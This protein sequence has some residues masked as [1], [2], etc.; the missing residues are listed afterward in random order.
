MELILL[1]VLMSLSAALGAIVQRARMIRLLERAAQ[2][3]RI[4]DQAI[5]HDLVRELRGPLQR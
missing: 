1:L 5:A 2:A 3:R 4:R